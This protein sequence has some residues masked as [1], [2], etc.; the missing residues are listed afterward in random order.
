M[1]EAVAIVAVEGTPKNK[2]RG[3]LEG[4]ALRRHVH[5]LARRARPQQTNSQRPT[6]TLNERPTI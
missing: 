4:G 6:P 3:F 5:K 1:I 2:C